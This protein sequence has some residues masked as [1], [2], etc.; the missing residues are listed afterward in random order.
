MDW[1]GTGH[2]SKDYGKEV[3]CVLGH[4]KSRMPDDSLLKQVMFG[5]RTTKKKM[6]RC[7]NGVTMI[8]RTVSMMTTHRTEWHTGLEKLVYLMFFSFSD[9]YS[10]KMFLGFDV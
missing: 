3:E 5:R 7:W 8:Q 2:S 10:F 1:Y 9:F 6:D 4:I